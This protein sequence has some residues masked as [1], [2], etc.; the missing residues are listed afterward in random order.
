MKLNK[1]EVKKNEFRR[2]KKSKHP[3]HIY[4]R[5]GNEFKYIGLTH[6]EITDG[7]KNIKLDKNPNPNDFRTAYFK[8][9]AQK[10]RVNNFKKPE[11]KWFFTKKDMEK[12]KKWEK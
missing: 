1:S 4:A 10:D 2:H 12:I 8:P 9:K 11:K 3:T 7:V 5:V 6:A